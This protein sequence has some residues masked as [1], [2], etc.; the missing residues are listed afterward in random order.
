MSIRSN[1]YFLFFLAVFASKSIS[2]QPTDKMAICINTRV[3]IPSWAIAERELFALYDSAAQI[4]ADRYLADNGYFKVVERWGGNDGPDDVMENF[5]QWPLYYA[6]GGS[7][8]VLRL[9]EKA[10]EGHIQQYT[11]A[12]VPTVEMAK[13]GMF[14]KEF[15][16]SFDWEH[17]GEG[18]SAFNFYGLANPCDSIYR[19][20]MIRFA[21]FYMNEDPE[22][23]NYDPEHKIIRSLHNGSL[24]PKLTEATETD[25]GGE[26]VEGHP[27]RLSR[28]RDAGNIRGDHPLNLLS[29]TLATNAYLLTGNDK[30]KK[31]ILEYVGAWH[32]RIMR[33][34]GNIPSNIGLDGSI[35]G[36][37]DGLW[38][39]GTFGW[40]FSPGSSL[41]N[42]SFRGPHVAMGNALLLT[43]DRE[44][45]T[46][47]AAQMKNL[48]RVKKVKDST[49]L[50]PNKFGPNGWYGYIPN[51]HRELLLDIC[52][53]SMDSANLS[54]IPND[55]WLEFLTNRNPE[56]PEQI[57]ATEMQS[58][59]DKIQ[60]ILTENNSAS[61]R[62]SDDP[63]KLNPLKTGNLIRLTTGGNDPGIIGNT[64]HCQV[65]YFDPENKRAGLP[66][67][68]AT[69][70][71]KVLPDG[72]QLTL[73]NTSPS[74][75][76]TVI[77]QAGA[78]GEHQFTGIQ[79]NDEYLELN[80]KQLTIHI[81]K[82][83]GSQIKLKMKRY[84]NPPSL[85]QPWAISLKSN[86]L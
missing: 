73:I 46:P 42:Y 5:A 59:N 51:K 23:P 57:L 47:L 62:Q 64:L 36:E 70:V 85:D 24:G 14:H 16:T 60:G 44:F 11:N 79:Y 37:W 10:W 66:D 15:I 48:F 8:T 45:I 65:R 30:Y 43:G 53:W 6:L 41:R 80:Q 12:K 82:H 28:Y 13:D 27:E 71:E 20:R 26:P 76:R 33:N 7:E 75:E 50:L 77:L 3:E 21:G 39:G 32:D 68:I 1:I 54:F 74:C 52:L 49:I 18:L 61:L 35:G 63:Q 38:Y 25:W 55:P 4:F 67:G 81:A 40:N 72:I 58:L 56:Y 9:Y 29:T 86:M 34:G 78:Y 2:A 84:V 83:S 31:W 17:N 19:E 22:A 69:L